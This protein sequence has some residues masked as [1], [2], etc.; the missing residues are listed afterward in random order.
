MVAVAEMVVKEVMVVMAAT[1]LLIARVMVAMVA[2][3]KME[4]REKSMALFL[5]SSSMD[6]FLNTL[7][8]QRIK[9]NSIRTR[10]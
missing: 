6:P 5:Y 2:M 10:Y 7:G 9:C 8:E 3:A 4:E 1:L